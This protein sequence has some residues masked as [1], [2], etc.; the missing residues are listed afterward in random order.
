[1]THAQL[2]S[3]AA[4]WLHTRRNHPIVLSDVRCNMVA[5]QPDVLGW[6]NNGVSTL[7]ECKISRADFLRDETKSHRRTPDRGMG[8]V[9]WYAT[10]RGILSKDDLPEGWGLVEMFGDGWSRARIVHTGRPFR[11]RNEKDERT[12]LVQALRRATEGWGRRMFGEA[13]PV[14]PDGDPHPTAARIIRELRAENTKLRARARR[15]A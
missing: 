10:P 9:R 6:T 14:S 7:I 13:A 8:Y 3:L 5:E 1:M 12:M 4:R 15:G 11:A 2:V